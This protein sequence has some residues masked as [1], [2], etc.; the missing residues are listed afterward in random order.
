[1]TPSDAELWSR[2]LTLAAWMGLVGYLS[3][4]AYLANRVRRLG[5]VEAPFAESI[6]DQRL[7]V[8]SFAVLPQQVIILVVAAALAGVAAEVQRRTGDPTGAWLRTAL[9][10]L[11]AAA[12]VVVL[13]AVASI[14]SILTRDPPEPDRAGDLYLRLGGVALAGAAGALLW[15]AQRPSTSPRT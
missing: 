4:V 11:G 9:T 12:A 15:T 2:R 5:N 1:M 7:E 8:L 13:V 14:V 3:V 10:S 6:W